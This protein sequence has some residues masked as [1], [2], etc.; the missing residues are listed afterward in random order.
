MNGKAMAYLWRVNILA[1][2]GQQ[3]LANS[4][5][6]TGALWLSEGATHSSLHGTHC[7]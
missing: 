6:R 2:D 5:T 1:A 4:Y 7:T 3:D